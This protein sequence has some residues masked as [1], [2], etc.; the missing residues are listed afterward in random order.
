MNA[1]AVLII[2]CPCA[3]GLATPISIMVASGRGAQMGVL[4]RD[5]QAIESLREIDTLVVD[6]TGTLTVGRP[7]LHEVL[8]VAPRSVETRAATCRRPGETPASIRW[9]APSSRARPA[10]RLEPVDISDFQS[11]TGKGVTGSR[12]CQQD[13]AGQF[14]AHA[15]SR[16][17][18]R[19]RSQA[20]VEALRNSGRTVMFLA[21]DGVL[22]GA[23]AVGD[24]IKD[25]TP[26]RT[27][28]ASRRRVCAS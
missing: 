18:T 26:R 15:G 3:L 27:R 23:I 12:A 17:R 24:P 11:V 28:R 2:A 22:A 14:R 4:F 25:S 20:E 13:R 6:K 5:A 7:A 19:R 1:V 16:A 8:T 9:R 21:V 10:R